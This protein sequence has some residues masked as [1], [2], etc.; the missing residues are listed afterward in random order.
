MVDKTGDVTRGRVERFRQLTQR[1]V[2]APHQPEHE[3]EATRAQV[4]L[5]RPSLLEQ[6]QLFA[7]MKD[8]RTLL[9][10]L[11]IRPPG[12]APQEASESAVQLEGDARLPKDKISINPFNPPTEDRYP[13][14]VRGGSWNDPP[15][16]CR[17]A[18][19][20]SSDKTWLPAHE[21]SARSDRY[22]AASVCSS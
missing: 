3:A 17:S 22:C 12:A 6:H 1:G 18:I 14:V 5:L 4:V 2:A 21:T 9:V 8:E 15:E 13:D 19:R 7:Q 11:G 10:R 16:K 20:R